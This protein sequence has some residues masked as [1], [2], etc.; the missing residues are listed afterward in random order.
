MWTFLEHPFVITGVVFLLGKLIISKI[1]PN[2][3]ENVLK[4]IVTIRNLIKETEFIYN[5]IINTPIDSTP[6]LK[7]LFE[8]ETM[9]MSMLVNERIPIKSIQ[10]NSEIEIYFEDKKLQEAHQKFNQELKSIQGFL[11]EELPRHPDA[12][13]KKLNDIKGLSFSKFT[14]AEDNLIKELRKARSIKIRHR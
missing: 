14:D 3:K 10:L 13:I 1:I 7:K 9:R 5:R 6:E 8:Q 4:K 12:F 2:K 11:W